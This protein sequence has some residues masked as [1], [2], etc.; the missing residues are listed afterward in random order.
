MERDWT[1]LYRNQYRTHYLNKVKYYFFPIG[2][3]PHITR[4][5]IYRQDG[6]MP[7]QSSS[8]DLRVRHLLPIS[9]EGAWHVNPLVGVSTEHQSSPSAPALDL[10]AACPFSTSQSMPDLQ[11]C[12]GANTVVCSLH[13]HH[14][15]CKLRVYEKVGHSCHRPS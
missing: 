10:R 12:L 13:V 3:E 7:Q 8:S 11:T 14:L 2:K 4:H 6:T 15:M 9:V 5:Q 1:S